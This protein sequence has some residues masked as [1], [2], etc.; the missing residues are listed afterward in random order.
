MQWLQDYGLI[1][2]AVI[3]VLL[4]TAIGSAIALNRRLA[5]LRSARGEMEKLG[6]DF[7]AA[8]GQ[9]EGG[10]KA[11]KQG[12]GEAAQALAKNVG[13]ACRLAEE[14]AFLV[15]KG[16]EI[17]DRLE[18]AISA[19]RKASLSANQMQAAQA[20]APLRMASPPAPAAAERLEAGQIG[21]AHV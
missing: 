13:D 9:A 12:S 14:M 4:V 19:S 10:L 18:V 16:N 1:L 20:A 2:D 21:R 7:A 11:L 17:A 3:C 15:K 6:A 5:V 8:T